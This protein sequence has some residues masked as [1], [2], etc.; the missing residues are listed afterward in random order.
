[1]REDGAYIKKREP[2]EKAFNIHREFYHMQ[3]T[4]E[5]VVE[6]F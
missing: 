2:N 6:I 5:E 4:P 3:V 1:M